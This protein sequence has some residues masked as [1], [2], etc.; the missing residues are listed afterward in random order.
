MFLLTGVSMSLL[1]PFEKNGELK[2]TKTP[3]L[4]S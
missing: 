1:A 2:K 4:S 3:P